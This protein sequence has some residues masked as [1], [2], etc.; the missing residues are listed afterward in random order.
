MARLQKPRHRKVYFMT[1]WILYG[2][3]KC[4]WFNVEQQVHYGYTSNLSN[5][6][7]SQSPY[8]VKLEI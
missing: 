7:V 2:M 8:S 5:M 4:H 6:W 1:L 3:A